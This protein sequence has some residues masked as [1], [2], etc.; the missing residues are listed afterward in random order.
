MLAYLAIGI[1]L[2]PHGLALLHENTQ[3]NRVAEFGIVFLMFS[4]GLEFSLQRLK[5]MR[6]LVFGHG[7][8]QVLLTAL[9]TG[10]VTSLAYGQG[11]QASIAVGL[12]V[13]MSSTAIVAKMLSEQLELNSRSGRQTMGVLLFQD[14]AV[15]PCLILLPALAAPSSN[16][17][18]S[19]GLALV[20]AVAALA[21]M[22]W[23]G[24]KLMGRLFDR[25]AAF[26]S[27][28]LFALTTVS[29]VVGLAWLTEHS[30][31]SL[32]LGAFVGG[33]LISETVYR[34]QVDSDIRPYRDMLLGLFFVTIGM[35]LNL[36]YVL[37]H[38][39]ILLLAVG[40][41]IGGKATV[42]VLI[43]F[44]AKIPLSSGLRSA[45]QLAQGGE[46]GL[47]LIGLAQSL[48]LIGPDVFQ[49]SLSAMLISMFLAPFIIGRAARLSGDFGRSNWAHRAKA[50]QH[51]G[52]SSLTL[53]GHVII[54]GFGR[55]GSRIGECLDSEGIEFMALDIDPHRIGVARNDGRNISF[56]N[57]DRT[58]VLQAAGVAR[59]CAVVVT[60]PDVHSAERVIL[61]V[62][63]VRSDV[64]IIV[65][66]PN[67]SDVPRLKKLGANE[68]VSEILEG[69]L[70]M[71]T[72]TLTHVGVPLERAL[73]HVQEARRSRYAMLSRS[74]G[75][76]KKR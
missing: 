20:Q 61:A 53:D 19:L 39:H 14:I 10:M 72:E 24:Q 49:M 75:E 68:V 45:A 7:S 11:W 30:G 64:A 31:L 5:A 22:I 21:L 29:I 15:V 55:T 71:A 6:V 58:E 69:G 50:I 63:K 73:A 1:A 27:D 41:L 36:R 18:G 67:E 56:G 34:H 4:I 44:I 25:V 76:K 48:R 33:M 37:Q 2:G 47:V 12:A 40:L 54:C 52:A 17:W 60:Y 51:I 70:L 3:V 28:E 59:A 32:A 66:T 62:R 43:G 23:L 57:A 35:E 26:H 8:A 16:L 38:A 42:M 65:R 74:G 46:F 13:S 9:G